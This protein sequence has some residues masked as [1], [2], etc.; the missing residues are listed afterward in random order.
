MPFGCLFV[1]LLGLSVGVVLFALYGL[2]LSV[3]VR[4]YGCYAVI[5]LYGLI[6]ALFGLF[7]CLLLSIVGCIVSFKAIYLPCVALSFRLGTFIRLGLC[8][9]FV[10]QN[11]SFLL[12]LSGCMRARVI[13]IY[14]SSIYLLYI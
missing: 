12:L 3:C 8:Y 2:L 11:K 1:R 9:A 13:I 4:L 7:G 6:L 14:Y 5:A 10:G